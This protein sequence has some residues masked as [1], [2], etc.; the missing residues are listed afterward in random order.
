MGSVYDVFNRH[1]CPQHIGC[2]RDAHQA[3]AFTQQCVER[4]KLQQA[5]RLFE[6]GEPTEAAYMATESIALYPLEAAAYLVLARSQLETGRP[7]LAAETLDAADEAGL[8]R[9]V[10]K[11]VVFDDVFGGEVI[12]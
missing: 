5:S 1:N 8:T 11:A 9:L 4:I 10:G 3:S 6:S 12:R 2:L 7:A